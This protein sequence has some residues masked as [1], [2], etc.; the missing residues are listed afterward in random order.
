MNLLFLEYG[1]ILLETT[2]EQLPKEFLDSVDGYFVEIKIIKL[3][4]IRSFRVLGLRLKDKRLYDDT[5]LEDS[6][7][8]VDK[9]TLDM[10]IKYNEIDYVILKEYYF[11]DGRSDNI[12]KIIEQLFE[13]RLEAKRQNNE[14]LFTTLKLLMNA[15]YGKSGL[16]A[17]DNTCKYSTRKDYQSIFNNQGDLN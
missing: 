5:N 3:K 13:M 12:G 14:G 16:N 10:L 1:G 6:Y 9:I 2:L 7:V 17:S 8:H 4:K 11:N 15:C